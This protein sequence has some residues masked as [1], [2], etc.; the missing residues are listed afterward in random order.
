MF[1]DGI[2]GF[3][4]DRRSTLKRWFFLTAAVVILAFGIGTAVGRNH[5]NRGSEVITT[6]SGE[7]VVVTRD[8]GGRGFPGFF[9]L[10][11]LGFLAWLAFSNRGRNWGNG[12]PRCGPGGTGPDRPQ[13]LTD[14]ERDAQWRAWHDAQH[15]R[16]NL[17]ASPIS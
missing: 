6:A 15:A 1:V 9:L 17:P 4:M 3:R 10:I 16:E 14:A 7:T 13:L 8:H 5:D 12:G 11:P 2:I